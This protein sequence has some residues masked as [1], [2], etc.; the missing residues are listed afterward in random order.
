M[1]FLLSAE[2]HYCCCV[3]AVSTQRKFQKSSQ[4]NVGPGACVTSLN[5]GWSVVEMRSMHC[6]HVYG[7]CAGSTAEQAQFC[8]PFHGT[9]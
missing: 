7:V 8:V 9:W 3:K 1:L 6:T 5:D 4:K 2:V